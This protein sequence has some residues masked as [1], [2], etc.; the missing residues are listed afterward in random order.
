MPILALIA[1]KQQLLY[2]QNKFRN[3]GRNK[4]KTETLSRKWNPWENTLHHLILNLTFQ[5]VKSEERESRDLNIMVKDKIQSLHMLPTPNLV[6]LH[7]NLQNRS[8]Q[9]LKFKAYICC[10][11]PI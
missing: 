10:Q 1:E 5:K 9:T 4:R 3:L 2:Q 6:P 7:K 11:F 8:L